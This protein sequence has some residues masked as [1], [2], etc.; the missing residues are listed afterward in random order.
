MRVVQ[1][2]NLELSAKTEVDC[3]WPRLI[4]IQVRFVGKLPG[5]PLL[6]SLARPV[7]FSETVSL[8]K[9]AQRMTNEHA[10]NSKT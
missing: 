10:E 5:G 1:S 2:S 9:A 7:N 6:N 8:S 4:R 3:S